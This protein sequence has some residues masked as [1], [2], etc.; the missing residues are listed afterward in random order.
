[1]HFKRSLFH[2]DLFCT[3]PL[4]IWMAFY[5][6]QN[7]TSGQICYFSLDLAS[8]EFL[9]R[10][11]LFARINWRFVICFRLVTHHFI[12]A[13]YDAFVRVSEPVMDFYSKEFSEVWSKYLILFC[14]FKDLQ[15]KNP[16]VFLFEYFKHID[17]IRGQM[18]IHRLYSRTMITFELTGFVTKLIG[19][20]FQMLNLDYLR[21]VWYLL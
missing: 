10:F 6:L 16:T 14:L 13:Y 5:Y 2:F 21:V 20:N 15:W 12:S 11:C 9:R 7:D 3:V 19:F 8:Q 18:N 1:M 17:E 4:G